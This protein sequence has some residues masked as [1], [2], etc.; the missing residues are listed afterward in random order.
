MHR[1]EFVLSATGILGATTVG[2][3]AYTSASVDRSVTANVKGDSNGII[4]LS[5]NT[6]IDAVKKADSELTIDVT[7]GLNKNGTFKYGNYDTPSNTEA[8]TIT[9]ADTEARDITVRAS[10]TSGDLSIQLDDG[11]GTQKEVTTS[12]AL[13]YSSVADSSTIFASVKI[14]TPESGTTDVD[15]TMTIES[16]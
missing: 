4:E 15:A 8:F 3:I 13:K 5:P 2:S 6:N 12:T 11:S 16:T 7:E 1:R 9:N 10:A 14:E